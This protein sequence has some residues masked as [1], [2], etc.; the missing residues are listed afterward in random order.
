MS[1]YQT[2]FK[3]YFFEEILYFY[4]SNKHCIADHILNLSLIRE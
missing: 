4:P 2:K 3:L 1:A